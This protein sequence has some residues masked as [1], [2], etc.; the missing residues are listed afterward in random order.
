MPPVQPVI[1]VALLLLA[2]VVAGKVSGRFGVPAL[3]LFLGIGMAAG[4]EGPGGIDFDDAELA[5][6]VGGIALAFILFSGGL[7]T[8]WEAVRTVLGHGVLLATLGTLIT[9]LVAGAAAAWIFDMPLVLG[10]LLGSIISSTDAAAVFSVLRSRGVELLGRLRPLLEFESASNDPMAVFL[11]IGLTTLITE[12]GGGAGDLI[13]LF[14]RQMSLGATFGIALAWAAV[15][16]VN[17]LRLEYEGLYPVLT[18]SI[19]LIVFS[20][21]AAVGGS[22]YLAVYL[23][24]V[25]MSRHRL[26]HKRSLM[27]FHDGVSWLMQITMFLLL[28]LLVYPSRLWDVALPGLALAGVLMFVARP[29]AV[30]SS[31]L[32]RS[33]TRSERHLVSW[34]GLRGAVP[35][36]LA[37]IPLAQGVERAATMFDAVFFVVILS[38]AFQGT[39]IPWV[40]RLL[41]VEGEA[42]GPAG[43]REEIVAGAATGRWLS[44]LEVQEESWV[45]GRQ[46]VELDLPSGVWLALVTRG[47]EVLV[48]QGPTVLSGGDRVTVLASPSELERVEEIFRSPSGRR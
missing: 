14:V 16:L 36:I 7:D 31:L 37:T 11:T 35:I 43:D 30:W 28:G 4:S 40:A 46:V 29:V 21:T 15:L 27:R 38:V 26:I 19:V 20:A 23:A 6:A 44:E 39:T 42:A 32:G 12:P 33:W 2:G 48:P 1:V 8:R 34:V 18:L 9:A 13:W 25:T 47:E 3:L 41:G 22:G 5:S 10:L 45:V 17:R 24:G